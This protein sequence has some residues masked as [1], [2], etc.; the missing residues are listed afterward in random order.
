MDRSFDLI[1]ALVREEIG[2][3]FFTVD[4]SPFSFLDDP[5]YDVDIISYSQSRYLLSISYNNNKLCPD[6]SFDSKQEAELYARKIVEK[7]RM[8]NEK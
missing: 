7:H 8:S 6:H 4:D 3:N 5:D 1:R 2:R